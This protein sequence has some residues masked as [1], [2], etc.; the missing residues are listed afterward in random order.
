[1]LDSIY[2][3][4]LVQENDNSSY[5]DEIDVKHVIGIIF[6]NNGKTVN[7]DSSKVFEFQDKSLYLHK[8]DLSGRPGLFLSGNIAKQ[9]IYKITKIFKEKKTI[10][11]DEIQ[12]FA[13][14]KILW[15]PKGK[16]VNNKKLYETLDPNQKNELSEI[17]SEFENKKDKITKDVLS[18]LSQD[19][20]ERIL[21][22]IM[23][24]KNK[25]KEKFVG[26]I[27]EYV[28]FFKNGLLSKRNDV[29][30]EIICSVCN[31]KKLIE[32]FYESPLPFYFPDKHTFFPDAD[33]NQ[34]RKGFSLCDDC[35]IEI[36]KGCQFIKDVLNY[37]ISSVESAKSELNFWLI[38]HLSD[39]SSVKE[40]KPQLKNKNLYLNALHDFC[41]T[42]KT[43]TK[44]ENGRGNLESILRFSALFYIVDDHGLMRV[45]NYVQ[46][47]YPSQMYKLFEIKQEIDKR[48]PFESISSILKRKDLYVGMPL[49]I[50]FFKNTSPQWKGQV[51]SLLEKM[52]TGQKIE[53]NQ[54]IDVINQKI[55]EV[56]LDS[57][58]LR[59]M[60]ILCFRGLMLL[61]YL[62]RLYSDKQ[63]TMSKNEALVP[64][65]EYIQKFIDEHKEVLGENS[66]RAIFSVGVCVGILLE[67]QSQRYN[68]TAPFW[69]RLNCLNLELDRI[70]Q[71]F[72]EVKKK[73]AMYD[74]R[75]FDTLINYLGA[76]E[77]SR[78]N[79][80]QEIS[81]DT[82]NFIFSLG[83]SLG[84]LIKRNHLK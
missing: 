80:S 18:L 82:I 67:V 83:L 17:F 28:K 58:S 16:L 53:V 61:E 51:I 37:R 38:P 35:Y 59:D 47:I 14:K 34:I 22:T 69:S 24:Q 75:G 39:Q 41:S 7:Y 10:N 71:L 50:L 65:I 66:S 55:R 44:L 81:K 40:F 5:L 21:V 12:S 74:E 56:V 73:L 25:E 46:G 79:L 52:F 32:A 15:F 70:I 26:E 19:D 77:I 2:R 60:V 84:Y 49:F 33:Q 27:P 9:D 20:P 43:I 72:P 42:L 11:S 63:N 31:K 1:M 29:N 62:I 68:K 4:G 8:R 13:T 54:V 48:Y 57:F 23:I 64:Q 3:L 36:Q 6:K 78:L 30:H 45:E 76:N